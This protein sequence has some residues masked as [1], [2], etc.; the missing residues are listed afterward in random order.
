[1]Q[2]LMDR[3]GCEFPAFERIGAPRLPLASRRR[4]ANGR[5]RSSDR[6]S[7][8]DK[9][10]EATRRRIREALIKKHGPICH[11]CLFNG[12]TDQRALIDLSLRWPDPR[13]FVRDHVKPRSLKGSDS[14]RNQRPAHKLCNERRGNKPLAREDGTE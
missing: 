4:N 3:P 10:G 5:V 12:I 2:Y 1:M 11:I 6:R 9:T 13:S 14:I 7:T 8:T